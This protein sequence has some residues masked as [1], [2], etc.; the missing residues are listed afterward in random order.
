[1]DFCLEIFKSNIPLKE[2]EFYEYTL[3]AVGSVDNF[4]Q[5]SGKAEY[6]LSS[7]NKFKFVSRKGD[8]YLYS[9]EQ[10][11]N[12]PQIEGV[13]IEFTGCKKLDVN[14][15]K[16]V[17]SNLI[18]YHINKILKQKK[19]FDEKSKKKIEKYK[20]KLKKSIYNP[21]ML[22]NE[23]EKY[24]SII[25]DDGI[26]VYRVFDIMPY[27]DENRYAYLRCDI[28]HVFESEKTIYD[29]MKENK[30]II[31]LKVDYIWT[32][33]TN[34]T[35]I[36]EEIIDKTISDK[37]SEL[38]GQSLIDYFINTNQSY[39]VNKFT[40]EDKKAN[41]IKVKG[42][43]KKPLY[44]IPHSLKQVIDRES[45]KKIDSKF[46]RDIEK[47]IKMNMNYRMKVLADFLDDIGCIKELGNL[48]FDFN[49]C[50]TSELGFKEGKI[51][52]PYVLVAN[53]EK[54]K[55]K[56]D[57]FNKGYFKKPN[58]KIRVAVMCPKGYLEETKMA[59][60]KISSFN[61]KGYIKNK[62]K[63]YKKIEIEGLLDLEETNI[64]YEYNIGDITEY[65]RTALNL[66]KN[67]EKV[68][69]V[70]CVIPNEHD[71]NNP[72]SE[73]KTVWAKYKIP[74]QMICVDSIKVINDCSNMNNYNGLY[75]I[76]EISLGMLVK[77]GGVPWI[78][79]E[80]T[81]DVDCF[82][83]LDVGNPQKGI[84][85]P[86]SSVLFDKNG[87]FINYFKPEIPQTGEIIVDKIL[88]EIF[89]NIILS[90][91]T[92]FNQPPKHIVIH[93]DGFA[94]EDINW[95]K[96]YFQSKNIKFDIVEVKKQGAVKFA[97]KKG[98]VFINPEAGCYV[99]NGQ[100]AYLVTND[101]KLG[102][103]RPLKIEKVYGDIPLDDIVKQI[104]YLS[105]LHVGSFKKTRLPVTT[106]YA[107]RI[108]KN[109]MYI[110]SG[111]LSDKLFFL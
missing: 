69:L 101:I 31:G 23:G 49:L 89:D 60:E 6:A 40:E 34:S 51:E 47:Y 41:V 85:Y 5:L 86:S 54:I 4:Y 8:T 19:T 75:Y 106:E 98:N 62:G 70:L 37:L 30:K 2:Q 25:N 46:S 88:Q 9:L 28:R 56:R 77:S 58:N 110:P 71:E 68:D 96:Q 93:R 74:S 91:E 13:K 55:N 44:F 35:G 109:I 94:R 42:C 100:Y 81:G 84:R 33:N 111:C 29:M 95:Y 39:R 64:F 92:K 15:Y 99:T 36:I 7:Q 57:V 63:L 52:K 45:L 38:K 3:S 20:I 50:R 82:I 59:F 14:N 24:T 72:Y 80:I 73:F 32:N 27:I 104:Y 97:T 87:T 17:Y 16:E 76:N 1:M 21:V 48:K 67:N 11:Q 65:K 26:R 102:S 61:T 10:L 53:K 43:N 83:G 22:Q 12:I 66:I 79:E 105:E 18:A 107:D 103:P 108:S 78:L 90:F